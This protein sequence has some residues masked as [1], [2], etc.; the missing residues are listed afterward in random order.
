M[1]VIIHEEGR[2]HLRRLVEVSL[3]PFVHSALST[4]FLNYLLQG[5][6]LLFICALFVFML[7]VHAALTAFAAR[8]RG[9][10][11]FTNLLLFLLFQIAMFVGRNALSGPDEAAEDDYGAGMLLLVVGFPLSITSLLIGSFAGFM[12]SIVLRRPIA[13]IRRRLY[14]KLARRTSY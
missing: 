14:R 13:R 8:G 4:M 5:D 7:A 10:V 12:L 3:A 1:T 6:D 9:Y 11:M 2:A